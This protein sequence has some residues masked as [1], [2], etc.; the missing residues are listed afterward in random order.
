MTSFVSVCVL[1]GCCVFHSYY[2]TL[3]SVS[4]VNFLGQALSTHCQAAPIPHT[5]N[6][7]LPTRT[8]IPEPRHVNSATVLRSPVCSSPAYSGLIDLSTSHQGIMLRP[9]ICMAIL[10]HC[11]GDV[12]I[13]QRDA[14]LLMN[15]LYYPLFG[16]TCFGLSP[17]HHQQHHLINCI[18]YWYV[19]AIRRVQLQRGC[20]QQLDSPARGCTSTQ[21]LDSP[22][23]E[24]TS[25][26]QLD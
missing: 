7:H 13:N 26:Q 4:P 5:I 24:C 6:N 8:Q 19:R 10:S 11:S 2:Q 20:T 21:Q 14:A 1:T 12:Q 16:S 25:T 23:R 17:V 15:D 18:T 22:T 9:G 3:Y